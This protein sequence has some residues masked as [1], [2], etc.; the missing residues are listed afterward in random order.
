MLKQRVITAL[1]LLAVI[2]GV[3]ALGGT[4]AWGVLMLPVMALAIHEWTRLLAVRP[5]PRFPF[6]WLWPSPTVP[7]AAMPL[8]PRNGWCR[9]WA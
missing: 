6:H 8:P 4:T 9:C 2:I 7:G 5:R 1:I 3:L